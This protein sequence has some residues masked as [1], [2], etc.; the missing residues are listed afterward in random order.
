MVIPLAILAVLSVVGGYV[1]VPG[2]LGGNNRFDKFWGRCFHGRRPG[3]AGIRRWA[4][5][6]RQKKRRR[7]PEPKSGVSN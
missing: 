5:K 1:G 2:S 3:L 4:K 6:V 7:G